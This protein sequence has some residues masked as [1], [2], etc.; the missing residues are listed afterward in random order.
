MED[1][2]REARRRDDEEPCMAGCGQ[3]SQPGH[4]LCLDC[5]EQVLMEDEELE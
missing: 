5:M 4:E 2:R 1:E 3:P